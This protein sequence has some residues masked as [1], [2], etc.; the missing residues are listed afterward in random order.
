MDISTLPTPALLLDRA[1]LDKNI[2]AMAARARTLK[3]NLRPHIK[4]H[5]CLEIAELQ[6][7]AGACGI[8]VSTFTEAEIFAQAGFKDITY[9]VPLEPGKIQRALALSRTM[10]LGVT[11]DDIEV[12]KQLGRAAS[13]TGQRLPVW[14]KVDCGYHRVGV[15]PS[16]DYAL[17][18]AG[19][20]SAA[21]NLVLAGLLTHAG[22][23]Y[24]TSAI[25]QIKAIADKERDILMDF[26]TRLVEAGYG[27]PTISVGATP[28]MWH[29]ED[30]AGIDEAR[31][32]NYVFHDRTQVALGSCQAGDCALTVLATVI[33]HQPDS[34]RAVIDAGALALSHDPGPVHLDPAPN[35]GVIVADR[36]KMSL[37]P[38]LHVASVS[39]EHGIIK[40][41][42]RADLDDLKVGSKVIILPNH[43]CL[44]AALFD[45][46]NVVEGRRV[47]GQWQIQRGRN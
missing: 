4:T 15:D 24:H 10:D 46:Y 35:R 45:E 37:H 36:E 23:A 2:A 41:K 47:I 43:S 38:T 26:R 32:G 39:Q 31:P 5:K 6:R 33:S 3:V 13:S 30:L 8:T 40:G 12:V 25:T 19:C 18:V 44:T 17:Q 20:I 1:I 42:S 21:G 34:N 14:L 9:A 28:T 16:S 11:V 22:H 27:Q 29:C 7:D